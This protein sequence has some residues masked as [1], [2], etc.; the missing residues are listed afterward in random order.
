MTTTRTGLTRRLLLVASLLTCLSAFA[1]PAA[2]QSLT[3]RQASPNVTI[4]ALD[5]GRVEL[6]AL[7]GQV[8]VISFWATWCRPCLQELPHLAGFQTQYGPQGFTVL[9]ISTDQPDSLP[10]VRAITRRN[11]WSFQV[12]LDPDGA[13]QQ[14]LNPRGTNPFTLVLDRQGRIVYAHEGYSSGD[15]VAL[16]QLIQTLLAEPAE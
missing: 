4:D 10:Q 15:E 13:V 2:A 1:V 14:L 3:D 9:A 16:E 5:G 6:A 8:V 7:R 11:S 12:L